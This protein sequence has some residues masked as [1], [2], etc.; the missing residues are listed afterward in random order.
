MGHSF[1][2]LEEAREK[3]ETWRID[4][5]D[6][7]VRGRANVIADLFQVIRDP[8]YAGRIIV[9]LVFVIVATEDVEIAAGQVDHI[10]FGA[11]DYDAVAERLVR[12]G[13]EPVR[14]QIPGG[15]PR[16][17]FFDDPD[18]QRVEINVMP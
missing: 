5:T 9:R 7:R 17:F 10:A 8:A 1:E 3:I 14:R 12:A 2:S 18:G 16:Q 13:V 11:T 6:S 4:Y 15:G